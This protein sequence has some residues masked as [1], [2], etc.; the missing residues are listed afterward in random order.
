MPGRIPSSSDILQDGNPYAAIASRTPGRIGCDIRYFDQVDSTQRVAAELA[1]KGIAQGAVVIAESQ[2]AGRGRL[3]RSWH[4]PAGVNLYMTVI[5]RPRMSLAEVPRLSLVAGVAV[6][7]ALEMTAPGLVA[8]KWPNDIWLGRRKAG[9]IIAEAMTDSSSGL[10]CVLLG[11]GLNLNLSAND[12]PAELRD[13][14]TSVLAS[15]GREVNRI[16]FAAQLFNSLDMH[17]QAAQRDGFAA[18][19]PLYEHYFALDGQRV[20][21][22]DGDSKIAGVVRGIDPDGALILETRAGAVRILTGDVSLEGAYD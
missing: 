19:R 4:S 12:I 14:A 21:V 11:I 1:Q 20:S 7:E 10:I 6:A 16:Q 9:G 18:V 15:T 5:L 17:Y 13:K 3:G 8:L 2:L 22:V